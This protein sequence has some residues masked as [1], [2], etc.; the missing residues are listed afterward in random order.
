MARITDA[1]R[2][3]LISLKLSGALPETHLCN[4]LDE[5]EAVLAAAMSDDSTRP[6][7]RADLIVGSVEP[8]ET[9]EEYMERH[10]A[11]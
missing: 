7:H 4:N 3:G 11:E 5:Y 8:E 9:F 1:P 10:G 2:A 6:S